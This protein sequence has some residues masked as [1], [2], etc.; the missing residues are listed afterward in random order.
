MFYFVSSFTNGS[1][2]K[3]CT[4]IFILILAACVDHDIPYNGFDDPDWLRLEIPT[5]REAY[6]IA[7]NIDDTLL[8]ATLFK[9]FYSIDQ[10]STWTESFNFHGPVMALLES[11]DTIFALESR[12]IDAEGFPFASL[13]QRFTRDHGKIW[14]H[15]TH[16]QQLKH[17][18]GSVTST[19]GVE[20]FLKANTT[21]VSPGST[22]AWINPTDIMKKSDTGTE[23]I[24]F[25]YKHNILNLH[26]DSNDRLYIAASGGLYE[27]ATNTF[28]CCDDSM[29]AIVY[30]SKRSMK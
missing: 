7:G 20:Y 11:N 15:N 13:A 25:P 5:G 29:S 16:N 23:S 21:P 22:T 6:S 9:V 2:M 18:I 8:V 12:G 24:S 14:M 30:V 26:M 19:S 10:G 27:E 4:L 1:V 28:Y 17:R 3:K